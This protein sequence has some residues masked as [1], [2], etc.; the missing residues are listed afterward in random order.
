LEGE[1]IACS[2]YLEGPV[3]VH[4]SEINTPVEHNPN[5]VSVPPYQLADADGLK[6]IERNEKLQREQPKSI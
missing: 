3:R 6:A 1:Q 2:F 4:W 5:M